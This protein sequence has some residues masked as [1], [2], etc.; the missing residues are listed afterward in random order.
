MAEQL[1]PLPGADRIRAIQD[2]DGKFKAF[3]SY[4]WAKDNNFMSGLYAIIGDPNTKSPRGTPSELAVHARTFYYAQRVGV[5][6]DFAQYKE[7]LAK[8]PEHTPP[9]VLPEAYRALDAASSA[10]VLA[11]QASAPK[12]DL[13]V[14]R[15]PEDPSQ[16]TGNEPAYPMGFAEMLE[17]IQKGLPIPG[18]KEIPDTVVRDPTVKPVGA[19]S[20]PRKPWEKD[21]PAAASGSEGQP[22]TL[23]SSFPPLEDDVPNAA[24]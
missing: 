3:D 19:R 23:D 1:P 11:W 15:K 13:Y 17:R 20:A 7:W 6:I 8:H 2:D 24:A 9:A 21:V 18:I 14:E 22:G 4:P 12:A 16:G 10:P 5:T